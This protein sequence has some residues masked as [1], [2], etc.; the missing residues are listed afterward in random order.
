MAAI[1]LLPCVRTVGVLPLNPVN[2][3]CVA[4]RSVSL[5]VNINA[6]FEVRRSSHTSGDLWS[7]RLSAEAEHI[8]SF[9]TDTFLSFFVS[10]LQRKRKTKT[11]STPLPNHI[12][13]SPK[14]TFHYILKQFLQRETT[15]DS[16]LTHFSV[17]K[18][19]FTI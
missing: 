14:S 10:I 2:S 9:T 1:C 12:Y 6:V 3:K 8:L 7:L 19:K 13:Y 17:G 18:K 11:K 5:R 16:S 4:Q 15:K